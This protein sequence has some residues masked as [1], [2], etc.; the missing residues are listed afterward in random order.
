VLVRLLMLPPKDELALQEG[1]LE[2]NPKLAKTVDFRGGGWL[3]ELGRSRRL[4]VSDMAVE[5]KPVTERLGVGT[6]CGD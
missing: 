2:K 4:A 6:I 5:S 1:R 3:R